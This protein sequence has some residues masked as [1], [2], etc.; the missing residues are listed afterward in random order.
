ME[1]KAESL[2]AKLMADRAEQASRRAL[3]VE[4]W[5]D[6]ESVAEPASSSLGRTRFCDDVEST[7]ARRRA[8]PAFGTFV[9]CLC[10]RSR[11][12][13]FPDT[14]ARVMGI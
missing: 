11:V 10:R 2:A 5:W 8:R 12:N 3:C 1:T 13:V 14:A 4:T 7:R 6:I 9:I